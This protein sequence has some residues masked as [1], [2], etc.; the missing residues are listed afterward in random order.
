MDKSGLPNTITHP[1]PEG[2][3]TIMWHLQGLW[4]QWVALTCM[5][6]SQQECL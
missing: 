6:V 1:K 2:H 3:T 4:S 5:Y